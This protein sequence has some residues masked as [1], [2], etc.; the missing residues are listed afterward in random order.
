MATWDLRRL[1]Q[2]LDRKPP[3]SLY[4]VVGDDSYL[5]DEVI[6]LLRDKV[7]RDG[8]IDFNY[9][10]CYS[11]ETKP[12][13]VRDTV[14]MLPMMC[15]RRMVI[16]RDVHLLKEKEWEP[17]YPLLD[18][19]VDSTTF[20]LV[21]E[22][23]DKRKKFFKKALASGVV[24]E[25]KRPYDNQVPMWIEY[26]AFQHNLE[27]TPEAV[28]LIQQFIGVNL[29]EI[30]SEI[31]KL[32]DYIGDRTQVEADDVMKAVSHTRI[33]TVFDLANAIGRNDRAAALTCLANLL[34]N[35]Q[36]EVGALALISR[37]VRILSVLREGQKT[38][39]SGPKLSAKAG[40]PSFF[41]KEYMAQI[42]EW[43]DLKIARTVRALHETDRAL[44]SSPVSSHIWL[45]NFIIRTCTA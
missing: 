27:M 8:A 26:I 24:V 16:Y 31:G 1:Q 9:D 36:N 4:L 5:Q 22:K 20:V 29:S 2:H 7:L 34:E 39:L 19:P 6:R 13:H 28:S 35:G 11:T 41:L 32:K 25:L 37:H 15:D 38:G 30:N 44:K 12:A 43:D 3:A 40:I 42:R 14:E 18:S 33:S 23:M 21:A 10:N 17:L 45:E